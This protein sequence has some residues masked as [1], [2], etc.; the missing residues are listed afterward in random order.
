MKDNE[1]DVLNENEKEKNLSEK[2]SEKSEISID[3]IIDKDDVKDK[4]ITN[5]KLPVEKPITSGKVE[6]T[7]DSMVENKAVQGTAP[8][9]PVPAVKKGFLNDTKSTVYPESVSAKNKKIKSDT[10]ILLPSKHANDENDKNDY[11]NNKNRNN[12]DNNNNNSN[13]VEELSS[14]QLKELNKKGKLSKNII[15]NKD[16][17]NENMK[18]NNNS[19]NEKNNEGMIERS[20]IKTVKNDATLENLNAVDTKNPK[21]SLIERG[22]VSMGDFETLKAKVASNRPAEIVCKIEVPLVTKASL[23]VLDVAERQIKFSYLDDY[24]ITIALPYPVYDK[25]GVAKY[26][27]L[28]KTLSVTIPVQPPIINE[29]KNENENENEKKIENIENLNKSENDNDDENVVNE[30]LSDKD[31]ILDKKSNSRWV[32][33]EEIQKDEKLKSEVLRLEIQK[34]VEEAKKII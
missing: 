8:I 1:G 12:Y 6:K 17:S 29:K 25:K 23:M 21:F 4:V 20:T 11:D 2:K 19:K 3:D 26:D 15:E 16:I 31:E 18:N 27:K 14:E 9:K 7:V 10:N 33:D 24:N 13:L 22:V 32:G 34:Q 28:A 5:A 30:K